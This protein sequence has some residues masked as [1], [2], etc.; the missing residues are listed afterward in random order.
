[1]TFIGRMLV[2]CLAVAAVDAG[3][4]EPL[5]VHSW[6]KQKLNE[7]FVGE[8]ATIVDANKDGRPDLVSGAWWYAGPTFAERFEYRP[9]QEFDVNVYS[10]NFFNFAGDFDGDGWDDVLIVGFPGAEAFWYENPQ[11]KAGHWERHLVLDVVDNESPGLYDIVG[12]KRP[13]LVCN[14][15]GFVGYAEADP[16]DPNKPWRFT[17]VSENR[18]YQRF[19]HGLGVGDVSGDRRSDIL[20]RE[21]WW[22]QP[23]KLG[24]AE[25]WKFHEFLFT[26]PGGA[27]MLVSDYDGD[28][29]NDVVTSKAA[30]SYGLAW[31]ENVKDGDKITFREHKITG[32]KPDENEY[33]VAFSEAHGLALADMD[34]DGV[35]DFVTGKRWWAHSEHDPGALEPAVLYWFRTVRENGT[36]KFVP[37][38]IDSDSGVGTQ[39]TVGDLN[40][41]EWPDIVVGSKKGT[42]AF[43]HEVKE[44][45]QAAWD[46]AQPKRT[47]DSTKPRAAEKPAVD[48][49]G[50][51]FATDADGRQLNL[52]FE[53][54][55]LTDWKAEGEA[56]N[57][58][59]VKGDTVHP[60]RADMVSGHKGDYWIGTF[61]RGGDGP[62]GTL[63]SIPFVATHPWASF[64]VGGGSGGDTRVEVVRADTGDV[65]FRSAGYSM[66][67]M[68]RA[69]IDL[70]ELGGK[71]IFLRITDDSTS[72]WGHV[73]FD[74]FRFHDEKPA[75]DELK[76]RGFTADEY[77][78]AGLPAE[79]AARAMKLPPGFK[80]TA[81][82][83]EPDI[84]QPIACALDDRGRM[85]VAEAYEYPIRAPEGKG[86]DRILIFEDADGDGKFEKR[87]IFTEGL[88]LVSGLE[89]GF[90]GVWVGAAPYLMFIPDR[91]GDDKPDGK[92]EILLDGW[93]YQDTHETLNAFTWGPDG[94]LYGCHGVFTHSLVGKPGTPDD[95]RVPINAA[96]WRYHPTRHKFERFAEGT[97]NPWGVDFDE[98]G[99]AFCTACV[100]PHLFHMIQGARYTRQGGLHFNPY[101]Y[102]DITTIA[103][104]RHYRGDNPHAGNGNSDSMGG[105]H[106]HAGAL[107]Y[108]GSAWPAD[109][110]GKL[111]MNNI[112][113]QR[114]NMD[115]LKP[116]GSGFVG[117]HGP[118]FL[119]TGDLASQMLYFQVAPDGN[120]YVIDWYDMNACHHT[121]VEGH[122]RT[123][124]RI[125][126]IVYGDAKPVSVDLKKKSDAELVELLLDK[127]EFQVRHARRLLQERAAADK[128]DAK[129]RERLSAIVTSDAASP[130]RLMALWALHATG[131][132]SDELSTKLRTDVDENVRGWSVRLAT[133]HDQPLRASGLAG[134]ARDDSSPVV[135]LFLASAAGR[136]P[137][138]DRWDILAGLLSHAEDAGDHNLPLMYWYAA[139]PLAE[140]DPPRAVALALSSGKTIPLVREFLLRRVASL[141]TPAALAA[142]VEP[143]SKSQDPGEQLAI[144]QG[145]RQGLE[146]LRDVKP[147][148]NWAQAAAKLIGEGHADIV[149]PTVSLGVKFGDQAS[150]GWLR[151]LVIAKDG[152]LEA[153]RDALQTL[154][155]AKD[156]QLVGTLQALLGEPALREQAIAGLANY[157]DKS[158]PDA[159]LAIYSQLTPSERRTAVATLS[160][161]P[162]YGLAL[163]KAI[164]AKT[165]AASELSADLVRQLNTFD[166]NELTTLLSKHWGQ[167]RTTPADKAKLIDEYRSL[168]ANPPI[169]PDLEL[170]R[171]VF[172]RTCQQC[173]VLYGA[174]GAVGPN[175]TGSNRA[176]LDYLLSNVVDPSAVIAKEYQTTMVVTVDGRTVSGVLAGEDANS[177]T[178]KTATETLVIPKEDIE[179]RQL[180]D[181]SVMPED[182]LKQFA[183]ADVV[184]LIAYLRGA[185]QVP[186]LARPDN[187][188]L[189]FN[190]RDL[191]GWS[192]ETQYWSV[193]NGEIVGK[194][195]GLD[196]NTFLASDLSVGDFRL[197]FEVK[198]VD[199]VGNSGVQFRTKPLEGHEMR[200]YQADIGATWWGKLYE[201]NG[202]ALLWDKPGDDRV[203]A[204]DWNK[205]VIEARGSHI[206]TWLNGE[207]CVDLDDP[208]GARRGIIALQLHSG[209]P[210]EVRY[211]DLKLEVLDAPPAS[212]T[213]AK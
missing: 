97:S 52:D 187:Q 87:T 143:L 92:P 105:G 86:R 78:F 117:S 17:P 30:H 104:H 134:M 81:A 109:Y 106:A 91:D 144:L 120:V 107:I 46:A 75:I 186:L 36:A 25:P 65:L 41:D 95:Q 9:P 13:E 49:E 33:G 180:T 211:R 202:R 204:G 69:A 34:R 60:R 190:G 156:A 26:E 99:Q 83:A 163:V 89:V 85:W 141:G 128:L 182:Q 23:E 166:D 213:S 31:F 101:T 115:I 169:A 129:T 151:K 111:F 195:P 132:V 197:S 160:S 184:S 188:A 90:G 64:L 10:E 114:L 68:K 148:A 136:L 7:K 181:L 170:G 19:T 193:D 139:E 22:E 5:R 138:A 4:A 42:F 135:R 113:G 131:G 173:H 142:L 39:V 43:T 79:E 62:K 189:L 48:D 16:S 191:S 20:L 32:E 123:N 155:A 157:D 176:D 14:H 210:T 44:V 150:F 161:R 61:E 96:L 162:D 125:Y 63:T 208:D 133:D 174:G 154:L 54:G 158:T 118:D 168:A 122:D 58:Q 53:T 185:A 198:L 196:H 8:G 137:L 94:W 205:Y 88:N 102:A 112:H 57:G 175:L 119:L 2:A 207:L 77:R 164:A 56:F 76:P 167:V 21:G 71:E 51:F 59:P 199:N 67:E 72:G 80:V 177:L 206:R 38:L 172:A 153:R 178:L 11:G 126:K 124:G 147:P 140:V 3:A 84:K 203:K 192:G 74:H 201:E 152:K 15:G 70:R 29:D 194:S 130:Q 103:D 45:D 127:N 209:E 27:Q 146:G 35:Q 98:H 159:L 165:I 6:A 93:A 200:G 121:N 28:G 116:R 108:Q 110:R 82:A 73:N 40:G 47:A 212:T 37:F 100:I 145:M 179:E 183:P 12:D 149:A 66:E 18:G 171:A 55:D 50:A 24:G 1:M